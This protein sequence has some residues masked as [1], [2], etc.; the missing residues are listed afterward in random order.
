MR[1]KRL[2][3]ICRWGASFAFVGYRRVSGDFK[4]TQ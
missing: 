3:K 2:G 4:F 1:R